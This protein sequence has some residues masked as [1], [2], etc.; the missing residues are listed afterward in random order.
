MI[1]RS[2]T[3]ANRRFGTVFL[4][5]GAIFVVLLSLLAA[6]AAAQS[7]NS[8]NRVDFEVLKV[9]VSQD[10]GSVVVRPAAGAEPADLTVEIEGDE[11]T[12]SLLPIFR[13]PISSQ[14]IIII[15]DS[16]NADNIAGFSLV[17][18]SALAFVDGLSAD[19]TVMLVRGGGGRLETTPEVAF[20]G[21]HDAVRAAING[22]TPS[23]GSVTFNAIADSA[24]FFAGQN[25]GVRNVVA[26]I[27]SPGGASTIS[28]SAA[29]G[30]LLTANASFTV[31][32]PRTSNLDISEYSSIA[33][34]L[35]GGAVFRGVSAE[36]NMVVAGQNAV[37]TQE[38]YLVG[39]F[40]TASILA[41]G[42]TDG[43][44]ED[45]T[46]ELVARYGEGTERVRIV[47][48]SSIAGASL[49]AP[50]LV[51]SSRFAILQGNLVAMIAIALIVIAV[52]IFAF[53]LMNIVVGS[54]NT[55]NSTLSVYGG[56]GDRTD[57]QKAADDAFAS[58][59][60]KIIEQVVER[61]EEAAEAR[62]NLNTTAT[63]L[64]KAE[65][66]LRVGEAFALQVGLVIVA[67][68]LGFLISGANL[69]GGLLLAI[70]AAL[71]PS[72]FV[73]H[74]VKSRAK[75][76]E[77]QLPDTLNL[78]S[79]TLKAGYSFLQGM[80]A[81]G[82]EAEEPLAGEF[83]RTVNEARL[84]KDMDI[85]LDDLA[86]RVDSDDM[87][88]AIVAIKIQR[89]VGGNLAELLSTVADTMQSRTRLRGEVNALTAE[90]RIS[91]YVL[92]CLPFAVALAMYFLNANYLSELWTNT[93]GLVFVGVALVSMAIGFFWM[94]K[95]VDIQ[96]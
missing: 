52:L 59:R 24:A 8:E 43:V 84:G 66:P 61:A 42:S 60:S 10:T 64:E 44:G 71:I 4:S 5:I 77:A 57:E 89:E 47:P 76:L 3:A 25:D 1:R 95:I 51:E 18:E 88:W 70:L 93:I 83:R 62:G 9:D 2:T 14:T 96:L 54:D 48:G 27:G 74:K 31:V 22:L 50:A 13:S 79:S 78:L 58:N 17:R 91:S 15:D 19:T 65:I 81:V 33:D 56:A 73:R 55:L 21:N 90:G 69:F 12:T 29:Q 92:I 46:N 94:R 85:A 7:E 36:S 26:F 72:A 28:S 30:R 40:P 45:G 80:D 11:I 86:E 82:N 37:A 6:P 35:R 20:T 32:A 38:S 16:E 53:T 68:G 41:A 67:F 49:D 63:M 23:G 39:T 87:L 34:G 75:K